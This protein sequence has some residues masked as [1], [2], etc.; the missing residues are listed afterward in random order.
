MTPTKAIRIECLYCRNG[1]IY[2]KCKSDCELK[3]K[4]LSPLKRIKGYC[5]N[6]TPEHSY[7]GVRA[8]KGE[9]LNPELHKCPLHLY[10]LGKNPTLKGKRGNFNIRDCSG[11]VQQGG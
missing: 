10:R 7:Q 6:C 5:L 8:C 11:F 1:Q 2:Y 9:F 4:K 3:N